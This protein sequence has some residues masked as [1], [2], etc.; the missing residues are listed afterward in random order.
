MYCILGC[1]L[2]CAVLEC[3]DAFASLIKAIV[4]LQKDRAAPDLRPRHPVPIAPEARLHAIAERR[5][6]TS[7]VKMVVFILVEA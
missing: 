1:S 4:L 5:Q 2:G 6:R 3:A 7:S